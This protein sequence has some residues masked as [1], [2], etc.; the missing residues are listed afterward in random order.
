MNQN[1]N[2]TS[3]FQKCSQNM[4]DILAALMSASLIYSYQQTEYQQ[5]TF[6]QNKFFVLI[7]HAEYL[8]RNGL[9]AES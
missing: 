7:E 2:E 3:A 8:S 9:A 1:N 5:S 4:S 6:E